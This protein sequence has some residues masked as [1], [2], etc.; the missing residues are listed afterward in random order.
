M[1]RLIWALSVRL[2]YVLRRY[3]PT[4]I[5]LDA[6]RSRRGLKFGIPA[7]LLAAPYLV[8]A[9]TCASVISHGGPGWLNLVVA[10]CC[11]NALKLALMGPW[12]VVLLVRARLQESGTNRHARQVVQAQR[13]GPM[14]W[15]NQVTNSPQNVQNVTR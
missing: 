4:N 11:W 8:V 12:S 1:F 3:T 10:V 9:S 13:G 7:M 6:I 5:L 2:R 14:K 15:T